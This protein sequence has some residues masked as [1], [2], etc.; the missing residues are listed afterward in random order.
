MVG[1]VI[2]IQVFVVHDIS[3]WSVNGLDSIHSIGQVNQPEP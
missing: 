2:K 3:Y 1:Q